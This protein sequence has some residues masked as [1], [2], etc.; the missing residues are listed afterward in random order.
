[1]AEGLT[2]YK[3]II[4]YMLRRVNFP[5]SNT[6]I[7][8]YMI[9]KDYTDYFHVQQA[10]HDLVDTKLITV[11]VIRNTSLYT[12]TDSGE[13]TLEYFSSEISYSIKKEIDR[14]LREN[15]FEL[16]N[17][18]CMIADWVQTSDGGCEVT[19]RVTEGKDTV[20]S[21]TFGVPSEAEAE[22]VCE[23]WPGAAQEIY[24]NIMMKLLTSP[25]ESQAS[26]E[27]DSQSR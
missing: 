9:E 16:R 20:I 11:E 22:R 8:E 5:L 6:Q 14:Y 2:L 12:A 3:L 25:G 1:M 23:R 18:S 26:H 19:C 7:T 4:L 13:K 17:E 15:A 10:L 27:S 21:V 24:V